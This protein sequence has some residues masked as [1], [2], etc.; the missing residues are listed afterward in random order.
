LR[1]RQEER[2]LEEG[3]RLDVGGL[4]RQ[5]QNQHVELAVGQLV[6]ERVGPR[7]AQVQLQIRI[8]LAQERQKW[9]QQVGRDRGNDAEVQRTSQNAVAVMRIV[10]QIAH[11]GDDAGGASR[12]LLAP[13]GQLHALPPAL[14][15]HGL[16]LPLQLLDLHRQR[17]LRDGAG[18]GRPPEVLVL[19]DGGEITQ[20]TQGDRHK[21]T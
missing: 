15:Q 3:Q 12:D 5:G 6:Q 19:G 2:V 17:R 10:D 1:Y 4:H 20:L 8:A 18:S 11:V 13:L 14:D 21:F 7:L 16:Q 9:R